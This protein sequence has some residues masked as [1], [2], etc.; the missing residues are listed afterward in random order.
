MA[1]RIDYFEVAKE[2]L[3]AMTKVEQ[4]LHESSIEF[5][6]RELVKLRASQIN[7]CAFCVGM[8]TDLLRKKSVPQEKLDFLPVWAEANCYSPRERAALAWAESVTL[9]AETKVPDEVY[10]LTL[11]HFS[12]Q[13]LVDLTWCIATINTWNRMSVAFRREPESVLETL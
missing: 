12:E 13:E 9:L 4:V 5:E 7:G 3:K 11:D 6:L 8:H 2:P 1:E 10:E